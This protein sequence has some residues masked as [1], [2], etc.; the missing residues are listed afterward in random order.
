MIKQINITPDSYHIHNALISVN[1][2]VD[3]DAGLYHL[4]K[5]QYLDPSVFNEE[6]LKSMSI[7]DIINTTYF[8]RNDNP[9]YDISCISDRKELDNLYMEFLEKRYND[10]FDRS[11]YTDLKSVV[12]AFIESNE[13]NITVL[14]YSKYAKE[15][16][17]RDQAEDKLN[18]KIEFISK[19]E[20]PKRIDSFDEV[21]LRSIYEFDNFDDNKLTKPKVFYIST[22][23]RNYDE[24]GRLIK[25]PAIEKIMTS[26]LMHE[27]FT[28]SLYNIENI[29]K[30]SEGDNNTDGR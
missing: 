25:L 5:E 15:Q 27:I 14:Y 3:I 8:R 11:V 26:K 1:A 28:Y 6:L 13:V 21:Y 29:H 23:R 16:L 2:L 7:K 4:I 24:L 18:K 12:N 19:E 30:D 10:I 20:L 17:E 22:F 9:L